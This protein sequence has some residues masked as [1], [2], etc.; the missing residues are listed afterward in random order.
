MS[1]PN[2]R[3]GTSS[4]VNGRSPHV[5]AV[6]FASAAALVGASCGGTSALPPPAVHADLRALQSAE[7][8][9]A[10][11]A[12]RAADPG[13]GCS[14]RC[15]AAE[16]ARFGADN[17]CRVAESTDDADID[18]RCDRAQS[19]ATQTRAQVEAACACGARR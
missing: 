9:L 15:E 5:F 14:S 11:G 7:A 1:I 19:R 16:E 18:T 3:R 2:R 12:A 4:P 8:R 17:A 10:R 13:A 6:F